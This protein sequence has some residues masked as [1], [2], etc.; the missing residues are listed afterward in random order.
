MPMDIDQW[1][2]L[3][4]NLYYTVQNQRPIPCTDFIS[5]FQQQFSAFSLV[6]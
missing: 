4:E 3:H 6:L 1:A 5:T 2:M